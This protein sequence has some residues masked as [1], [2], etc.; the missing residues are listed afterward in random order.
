ME[1]TY[2]FTT[3]FAT[4]YQRSFLATNCCSL[5]LQKIILVENPDLILP[6]A[7]TS[8]KLLLH[9]SF[10]WVVFTKYRGVVYASSE[11]LKIITH[12]LFQ[13]R[14]TVCRTRLPTRWYSKRWRPLSVLT[15]PGFSWSQPPHFHRPPSSISSL[16]T[17]GYSRS[18]EWANPQVGSN[19]CTSQIYPN[20]RDKRISIS[21]PKNTCNQGIGFIDFNALAPDMD[22]SQI[23]M[24]V[25]QEVV[26]TK[27][28]WLCKTG[29]CSSW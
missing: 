10:L 12:I 7:N 8:T 2:L 28:L 5:N 11:K 19:T 13:T 14:Q 17:F 25:S 26:S 9:C 29:L 24:C 22:G 27:A 16:S 15:R 3:L 23:S 18:T 21:L 4:N 6:E 1:F 20:I